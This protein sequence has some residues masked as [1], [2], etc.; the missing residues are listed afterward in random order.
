MGNAVSQC[1]QTCQGKEKRKDTGEAPGEKGEENKAEVGGEK[2]GE[3]DPLLEQQEEP[4]QFRPVGAVPTIL[5]SCSA[6]GGDGVKQLRPRSSDI[7]SK[8]EGE[9]VSKAGLK[10]IESL[11]EYIDSEAIDEKPAEPQPKHTAAAVAEVAKEKSAQADTKTVA[12]S[13]VGK[14]ALESKVEKL[15]E[16]IVEKAS[17]EAVLKAQEILETSAPTEAEQIALTGES[18]DLE[19]VVLESAPIRDKAAVQ[20]DPS[21]AE[22]DQVNGLSSED[23]CLDEPEKSD[24]LVSDLVTSVLKSIEG[25]SG[26]TKFDRNN[27]E[28]NSEPA[29]SSQQE[30]EGENFDTVKST[31]ITDQGE[32]TVNAVDKPVTRETRVNGG[33]EGTCYCCE[34]TSRVNINVRM[35]ECVHATRTANAKYKS[36]H[37][38]ILFKSETGTTQ[39]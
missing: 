4:K 16:K 35:C 32:A 20:E 36:I 25:I 7:S 28:L 11:L 9:I 22:Q 13:V 26:D 1:F 24:T 12:D 5:V 37:V 18:S 21:P 29:E 8:D 38:T 34:N 30:F 6:K 17:E 39:F 23:I 14:D 27:S 10:G 2:Q 33:G 19:P 15:S 31:K 3:L